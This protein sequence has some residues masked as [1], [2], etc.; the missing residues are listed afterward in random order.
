MAE[1]R[2][3]QETNFQEDNDDDLIPERRSQEQMWRLANRQAPPIPP[4]RHK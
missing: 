3:L 1:R 2:F 4:K